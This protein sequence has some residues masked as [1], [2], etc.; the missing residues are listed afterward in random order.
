MNKIKF[1]WL[2]RLLTVF[3][4]ALS[5]AAHAQSENSDVAPET[6]AE[7]PSLE[8]K[9]DCYKAGHDNF[10]LRCAATC[11]GAGR[12][13]HPTNESGEVVSNWDCPNS[14]V[15]YRCENFSCPSESACLKKE[16]RGEISG[17]SSCHRNDVE[18][19][20]AR[21]QAATAAVCVAPDEPQ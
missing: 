14:D 5:L 13:F 16:A 6:Q 10:N 8:L 7:S 12:S 11:Y 1:A 17:Y 9:W 4:L 18:A 3:P 19:C 20:K 2:V 21:A 15:R